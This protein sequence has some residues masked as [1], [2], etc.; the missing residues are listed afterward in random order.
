M[1]RTRAFTLVEILI[2]VVI[3]GIVAAIVLPKFSN[4][5]ATARASMLAD[6]LR[7]FRTQLTVYAGQ[8]CGTPAGYPNG[9]ASGSP[10]AATCVSQLTKAS[11]VQGATAES[12]TAGYT[13]GPYFREI[14]T[15]PV[16]GLSTILVIANGASM[17]AAAS[18]NYGWV[19]QPST[20]ILRADATGA[21]E[22]GKNFYDY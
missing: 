9:N 5:T 3:L 2:V 19:Y 4:A 15:N 16:N 12:G 17:P 22:T 18:G 14:P 8:H 6:D 20:L 7:V 21:D 10:D 1:N 13:Y 11:N